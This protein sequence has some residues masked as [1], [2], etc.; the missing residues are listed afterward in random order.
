MASHRW[1]NDAPDWLT[2]TEYLDTEQVLQDKV[3]RLAALLKLSRHTV[4]YSGAGVSTTAGVQQA[5]RGSKGERSTSYFTIFSNINVVQWKPVDSCPAHSLPPGS[6]GS[7]RE[8][9]G[10]GGA[11]ET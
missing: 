4:V 8:G 2:A 1:D 7:Q 10:A 3:E 6:G 11:Y 5:A 9:A